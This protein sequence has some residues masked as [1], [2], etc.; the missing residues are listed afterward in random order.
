MPVDG[1]IV[2]DWESTLTGSLTEFDGTQTVTILQ[3]IER[4]TT[5]LETGAEDPVYDL[6]AVAHREL[7]RAKGTEARDITVSALG[8]IAAAFAKARLGL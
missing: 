7:E 4:L 5:D 1:D 6:E 3:V 8:G 2:I